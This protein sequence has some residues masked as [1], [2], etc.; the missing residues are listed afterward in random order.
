MTS[1]ARIVRQ[2]WG[3]V[4]YVDIAISESFTYPGKTVTLISLENNFCTIEVDGQRREL[5]PNP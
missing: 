4:V 1:P 5:A 2:T 3:N